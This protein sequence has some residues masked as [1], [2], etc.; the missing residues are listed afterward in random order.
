MIFIMF[1]KIQLLELQIINVENSMF[2]FYIFYI[3]ITVLRELETVL[4]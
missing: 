4:F 1:F 2:L 3:C